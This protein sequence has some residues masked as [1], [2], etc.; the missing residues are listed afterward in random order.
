[1]AMN[2]MQRKIRN[3]FLFGFLIAI[4]I[5]AIVIALLFLKIKGLK[6]DM[7]KLQTEEQFATTEVYTVSEEIKATESIKNI[8]TVTVPTSQVPKNAITDKNLADYAETN[9]KGDIIQDDSGN[10][11]YQMKAKVDLTPNT[12]LTTDL[13]EKSSDTGT[14]RIIE[15]TMISLPSLLEEGD[16]IDIRIAYPTAEDLVILSKV[17]VESTNTNTVWLKLSESEILMLNNAIVESYIIDGTKLYAT[18]YANAAQAALNTTYAPNDNVVALMEQNAMTSEDEDIKNSILDKIENV[19]VRDFIEP[20]IAKYEQ[21]EQIDKVNE[22]YN[23]EKAAVQAAR[24]ALL[25]DLGY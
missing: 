13:V 17:K 24:E 4:I 1:M 14:Y 8:T 10:D 15:Y 2:P 6:E 22:G 16:Y 11:I 21:D 5:G 20:L 19:G 25:G 3:S 23:A 9:S 12:L 18:R 7:V